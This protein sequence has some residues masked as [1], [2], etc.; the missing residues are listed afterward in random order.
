MG[1]DAYELEID[2]SCWSFF[3]ACWLGRFRTGLDVT[4]AWRRL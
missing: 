4:V 2:S 3:C 1:G